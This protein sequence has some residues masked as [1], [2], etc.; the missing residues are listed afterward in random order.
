MS[1]LQ[2]LPASRERVHDESAIQS[3]AGVPLKR[4]QHPIVTGS[5]V[6]AMRCADGVVLASDTLG[7]YGSTARYRDVSRM[8]KATSSCVLGVGGDLSDYDE[9]KRYVQQATTRSYC[10]DDGHDLSPKAIHQY[11]ARIMYNRRNK[12]DPF[13]NYVV[14]A[15]VQEKKP[16]LGLVD[17]FGTHFESEVIA[18]G[19][20]ELLGLPLLR[21]A[22]RPDITVEEAKKVVI[23]I[24][25]VLFYRDART[26]DRVE[27]ATVTSAGAEVSEPFKLETKWDYKAFMSGARV[28][29]DSTW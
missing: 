12:M 10:H 20:G 22:Y 1:G 17:L 28:K 6:V 4:T 5:S 15:G 16:F 27:V 23:D 2:L 3:A 11:L 13:W 14:V 7:S 24:M 9:I 25:K 18:T 8:Y 26:I 29:D 19:F 21:K